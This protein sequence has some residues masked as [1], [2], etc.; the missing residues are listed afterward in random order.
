MKHNISTGY[1]N[2]QILTVT[3]MFLRLACCCRLF[4]SKNSHWDY[5]SHTLKTE[6]Y[7]HISANPLTKIQFI[8]VLNVRWVFLLTTQELNSM[9]RDFSNMKETIKCFKS[10]RFHS[11]L[12]DIVLQSKGLDRSFKTTGKPKPKPLLFYMSHIYHKSRWKVLLLHESNLTKMKG[13]ELQ[14]RHF[15]KFNMNAPCCHHFYW[16]K[17]PLLRIKGTAFFYSTV[18]AQGGV[19]V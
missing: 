1:H 13:D 6:L 5:F 7:F 9:P 18:H 10:D 12:Q 2:T 4:C 16:A 14:I 8:T 3:L 17:F 11:I 19:G 15:W